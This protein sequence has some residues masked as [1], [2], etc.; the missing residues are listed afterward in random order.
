MAYIIS[1]G[2]FE[3]GIV[4]EIDTMTVVDGSVAAITTV[5]PASIPAGEN[6]LA[7]EVDSQSNDGSISPQTTSSPTVPR[8]AESMN[9]VSP[10]S[11]P[12]TS[13]GLW[14]QSALLERTRS[15]AKTRPGL[16]TIATLY[17]Q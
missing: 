5:N 16:P 7:V 4:L 6:L 2:D 3:S 1:S 14:R 13:L 17:C 11:T 12:I 10:S 8:S 15:K 9:F